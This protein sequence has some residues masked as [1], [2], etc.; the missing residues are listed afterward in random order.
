MRNLLRSY[1]YF[2]AGGHTVRYAI[3]MAAM[4]A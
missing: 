2:R 1:R 3:R 4:G